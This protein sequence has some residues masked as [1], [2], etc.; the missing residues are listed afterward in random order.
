[1]ATTLT[2]QDSIN[3]ALPFLKNQPVAVTN[4]QPALMCAN[5]VL[6]FM[7]GPPMVWRFNRKE[8]SFAISAAGLTDY[9]QLLN[10]FGFIEL[11]WLTSG[12]NQYALEGDIALVINPTSAR[13]ERVAAQ[14]DDNAGDI[15]FRFDKVPDAS[16]T[17]FIDYQKKAQLLTSFA[18][19]WGPVPDEFNFIFNYG[20]LSLL[21]LLVNDARFPIFES[22]FIGRLL[23][24]QDGLDDQK[25]AIFYENW[26][27]K[28]ATV[29]REDGRVTGGIAGR[30]KS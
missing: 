18:S 7:L 19:S 22:Y 27:N 20:F 12:S 4:Q 8:I 3:W 25:R 15:T 5:I 11:A 9:V 26:A 24:A 29:K 21:C 2:V 14:F 1:M 6:G 30:S 23:A 10:D 28:M 13:P 17:A 16:Y